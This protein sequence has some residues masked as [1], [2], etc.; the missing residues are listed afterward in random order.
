MELQTNVAGIVLHLSHLRNLFHQMEL[1]NQG[2]FVSEDAAMQ[3]VLCLHYMA[4]G[5]ENINTDSLPLLKLL[6]GLSIEHSLPENTVISSFY[7]EEVDKLLQE[8]MYYWKGLNHSDTNKYRE[9][10][11]LREGTIVDSLD[12][13]E[14]KVV[15]KPNDFLLSKFPFSF[16]FYKLPWMKKIVQVYWTK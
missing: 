1:C 8:C 5:K 13:L 12:V 10:W 14:I 3:A 4:T 16:R 9:D 11:L 15:P 2:N 6:C 7:K